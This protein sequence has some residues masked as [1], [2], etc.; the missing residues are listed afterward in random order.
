MQVDGRET[1]RKEHYDPCPFASI[2]EQAIH[3]EYVGSTWEP[4]TGLTVSEKLADHID[5]IDVIER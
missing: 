1:T 5:Q 2:N 3:I 4:R